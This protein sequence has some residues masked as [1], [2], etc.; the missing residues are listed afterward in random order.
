MYA[1]ISLYLLICSFWLAGT[2]FSRIPAQ[3]KNKTSA[4]VI[5]SFFTPPIGALIAA[6]ISTFGIYLF[7]SCLYVRGSIQKHRFC[8]LSVEITARPMAHGIKFPAIPSL[9]SQF[10]K[11]SERLCVL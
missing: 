8:T 5:K 7:A 10:Y 3:L 1:V 11:C 9:G 6:A 2:A 4:E